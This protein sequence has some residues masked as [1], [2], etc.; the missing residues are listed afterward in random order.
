MTSPP[1][2]ERFY[3]EDDHGETLDFRRLGST[4]VTHL[5]AAAHSYLET[6]GQSQP[7][8]TCSSLLVTAPSL[9]VLAWIEPGLRT[10]LAFAAGHDLTQLLTCTTSDS[11]DSPSSTAVPDVVRRVPLPGVSSVRIAALSADDRWMALATD[12]GDVVIFAVDPAAFA[13][14]SITPHATIALPSPTPLASL[15]ANPASADPALARLFAA[16]TEGGDL[17]ILDAVAGTVVHYRAASPDGCESIAAVAWSR[18]GKQLA[19]A[20]P[21]GDLQRIEPSQW[22]IVAKHA[23]VDLDSVQDGPIVDSSVC[24]LLWPENDT[25]VLYYSDPQSELTTVLYNWKQN[26]ARLSSPTGPFPPFSDPPAAH[27]HPLLLPAMPSFSTLALVCSHSSSAAAVLGTAT[28]PTDSMSQGLTLILPDDNGQVMLPAAEEGGDADPEPTIIGLALDTSSTSTIPAPNPS[29]DDRP[30]PPMPIVWALDTLGRLVA[31]HVFDLPAIK[32]RTPCAAVKAPGAPQ[33]PATVPTTAKPVAAAPAAAIKP[34]A[35]VPKP[36]N[37]FGFGNSAPASATS[38]PPKV[39]PSTTSAF[40]GASFGGAAF[41]TTVAAPG[42]TSTPAPP[43]VFGGTAFSTKPLFDGSSTAPPKAPPKA[44]AATAQPQ[45]PKPAPAPKK[46]AAPISPPPLPPPPRAVSPPPRPME[47]PNEAAVPHVSTRYVPDG[48]DDDESVLGEDKDDGREHEESAEFSTES[49]ESEPEPEEDAPPPLP[50]TAHP[51]RQVAN[52]IDEM[53]VELGTAQLKLRD[54]ARNHIPVVHAWNDRAADA[55]SLATK[56]AK[57]RASLVGLQDRAAKARAQSER[58]AQKVAGV[59]AIVNQITAGGDP[60]GQT[61]ALGPEQL[62]QQTRLHAALKRVQARLE[63]IQNFAAS[64]QATMPTS[65]ARIVSPAPISIATLHRALTDMQT[66]IASRAAGVEALVATIAISELNVAETANAAEAAAKSESLNARGA[67][68]ALS[69][70]TARTQAAAVPRGLPAFK[71]LRDRFGGAPTVRITRVADTRWTCAHCTTAN[72]RITMVCSGCHT[73]AVTGKVVAPV[74]AAPAPAPRASITASK[75]LAPPPPVP[76]SLTP[77]GLH[78]R[79]EPRSA[80][81]MGIFTPSSSFVGTGMT[82]SSPSSPATGPQTPTPAARPVTAAAAAPQTTFARAPVGVAPPANKQTLPLVGAVKR[83]ADGEDVISTASLTTKASPK[84][85]SER[86]KFTK[87]SSNSSLAAPSPPVAAATVGPSPSPSAIPD[88]FKKAAAGIN[89]K[90]TCDSCLVA[91]A[92]GA[93][94]CVSCE[95]P[96]PGAAVTAPAAAGPPAPPAFGGGGNAGF[97]FGGATLPGPTAGAFLFGSSAPPPATSSTPFPTTTNAPASSA[98]SAGARWTC[99]DCMAH[100]SS[101]ARKCTQC[102]APKDKAEEG[103]SLDATAATKWSTPPPA[104]P[105]SGFQFG[106]PIAAPTFPPQSEPAPT[107]QDEGGKV[108]A[109]FKIPAAS[110]WT[111]DACMVT[112][113]MGATLCCACET[114]KAGS[115]DATAAAA[116]AAPAPPAAPTGGFAF[117]GGSQPTAPAPAMTGF[118]FGG[119]TPLMA[120]TPPGSTLFSS[121]A[122]KSPVLAAASAPSRAPAPPSPKSPAKSAPVSPEKSPTAQSPPSTAAASSS[123][124]DKKDDVPAIFKLMA[125]RPSGMWECDACLVRN[126]ASATKCVSCETPKAGAAAATASAPVSGPPAPPAAAGSL[127]FGAFGAATAAATN[128]P[129]SRSPSPAPK[130]PVVVPP[131]SPSQVPAASASSQASKSP[132]VEQEEDEFETVAGFDTYSAAGSMIHVGMSGS[133]GSAAASITDSDG[134]EQDMELDTAPPSPSQGDGAAGTSAG[135]G[136]M[137]LGG[138]AR[139]G[140]VNSMFAPIGGVQAASMSG[141]PASGNAFGYKSSGA[142]GTPSTSAAAAPSSPFGALAAAST[143]ASG[144]S[145]APFGGFGVSAAPAAPAFG[146]PSTFG[147]AA[148]Q[149]ASSA[150]GRTSTFGASSAFG[151]AGAPAFGAPSALG[152]GGGSTAPAFGVASSF[153]NRPAAPAF[154]SPSALG[155]QSSGGAPSFGSPTP[156]GGGGNAFGGGG[157]VFGGGGGGAPVFGQSSTPGGSG[158]GFA[159]LASRSAGAP[160]AFA[161]PQG[162]GG[163]GGF[164]A[165]AGQQ[166][167][168]AA[169]GQQQPSGFGALAQQQQNTGAAARPPQ[170]AFGGNPAFTQFRG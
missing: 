31:W 28:A 45:K 122:A 139:P 55:A 120:F 144:V 117:G 6:D 57:W 35:S 70:G 164:A 58:I 49:S 143:P 42:P 17:V 125:A 91:N 19:A 111:C 83:S 66:A 22:K 21:T 62:Q 68:A 110:K 29:D 160:A 148:M 14:G 124:K 136:S 92:A 104:L 38:A 132:Q 162:G 141:P 150:F 168:F 106:G 32:N 10:T 134:M 3:D 153:G 67:V 69:D 2:V 60:S 100:N 36:A 170:S 121:A 12:S 46:S 146:A 166:G 157:N 103:S 61:N 53:L 40:G 73:N 169:A 98:G 140:A 156:L 89:K 85:I 48:S 123:P 93:T 78:K 129:K 63:E 119:S 20:S 126:D 11:S 87:S 130:S 52:A 86:P 114:P 74:E 145:S 51:P 138:Q 33:V 79:Q 147:S 109:I 159:A 24:G 80:K 1:L 108:P 84:A 54:K 105:K 77:S 133:V 128:A 151:G 27:I 81:Q 112:N 90:W 7:P 44:P 47:I 34:A 18:K 4:A 113:D 15:V 71:Q 72:P 152:G 59:R 50:R 13:S 115:S 161:S 116:L 158:G 137:G 165:F 88:I 65:G 131:K 25:L 142:F 95:V 64:K 5:A 154:G 167:G 26:T 135:F 37:T 149:P 101:L 96:K 97:S 76:T 16:T 9:G 163:G 82:S 118:D 8:P 102:D 56:V 94:K 155:G 43:S 41:K 99:D 23:A 30:I 127:S 107:K 39:P 75:G